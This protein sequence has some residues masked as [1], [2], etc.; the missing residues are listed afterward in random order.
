MYVYDNIIA[1]AGVAGAVCGKLFS[2]QGKKCIVLEAKSSPFEKTC[3]G[4][5]SQNAVKLLKSLGFNADLLIDKGAIKIKGVITEKDGIL[6]RHSYVN[7]NYGIGTPRILLQKFLINTAES[8]GCE[9]RYSER[10]CEI[11]K[12]NDYYNVNDFLGKNF[13]SA[14]GAK[15]FCN[16]PKNWWERQ[17]FGISE[18]I[19]ANSNIEKDYVY[20]FYPNKDSLDYF[21]FIPI[22]EN[23]WNVGYWTS[24][25]SHLKQSFLY[26]RNIYV[27]NWFNNITV[28]RHP[29]GAICGSRSNSDTI[30]KNSYSIGDFAGTCSPDSGAGIFSAIKSAK[31]LVQSFGL[32]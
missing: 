20:F 23:I 3:G 29:K 12:E 22:S 30:D 25:L 2:E 19:K 4:L 7:N 24:S 26:Y 10:V 15:P 16:I 13:I 5:I 11:R 31:D 14:V 17:T 21:W 18:I 9:F 1:G 32:I 28:I 27:L 8:V 6:E